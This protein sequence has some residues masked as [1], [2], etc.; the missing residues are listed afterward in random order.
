MIDTCKFTYPRECDWPLQLGQGSLKLPMAVGGKHKEPVKNTSVYH[1]FLS[2]AYQI[3]G[4]WFMTNL[5][6]NSFSALTTKE[7]T[8]SYLT[9]SHSHTHK[10]R[11]YKN[12]CILDWNT[13]VT[14]HK[15]RTVGFL[16]RKPMPK[17][18]ANFSVTIC[19]CRLLL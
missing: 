17:L 19:T 14:F 11:P 2:I 6:S 1:D 16:Q 12:Q 8:V 13:L 10:T 4:V 7:I 3:L 5:K 18:T 15:Q 9:H